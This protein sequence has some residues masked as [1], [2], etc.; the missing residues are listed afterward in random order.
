M[1]PRRLVLIA[2]CTGAVTVSPLAFQA[3]RPVARPA[4]APVVST[5]E[6]TIDNGS[7]FQAARF[8]LGFTHG[9]WFTTST[10][11]YASLRLETKTPQPVLLDLQWNGA[12]RRQTINAGNNK[13]LGASQSFF[14]AM[15]GE[16]I[17]NLRS[18][19][20]SGDSVT[21]TVVTM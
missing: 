18:G 21:V 16:G 13:D 10:D 3:R 17:H 19:F 9:D 4:A 1:D 7:D 8:P 6:I 14:L 2:M 12:A 15:T 11:A 20:G 5:S